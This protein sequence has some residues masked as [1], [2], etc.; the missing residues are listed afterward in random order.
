MDFASGNVVKYVTRF[1]DKGGSD[2]L[3]KAADYIRKLLEAE[4]G[5]TFDLEVRP[6]IPPKIQ[7]KNTPPGFPIMRFYSLGLFPEWKEPVC[8]TVTKLTG[9]QY[10][11]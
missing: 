1:R 4:Y 8:K 3:V 6:V 2:D 10:A 11:N 5:L 7:F 9:Y